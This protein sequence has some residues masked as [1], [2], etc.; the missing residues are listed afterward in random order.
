MRLLLLVA[1]GACEAFVASRAS[2]ARGA[3]VVVAAPRAPARWSAPT[4]VVA[5]RAARPR[6]DLSE[7]REFDPVIGK[8]I[9]EKTGFFFLA[10][11]LGIFAEAVRYYVV[12]P[13]AS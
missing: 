4:V 12:T 1:V 8:A 2:T 5:P 7:K 11:V 6:R 13:H 9:A 10:V 3:E